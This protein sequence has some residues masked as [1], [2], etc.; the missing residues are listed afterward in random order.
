MAD[1][2][3]SKHGSRVNGGD[4]QDEHLVEDRARQYEFHIEK[5]MPQHARP[6]PMA[7]QLLSWLAA[8]TRLLAWP[9][10][11]PAHPLQMVM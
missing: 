3:H 5:P 11:N 2:V 7:A 9:Q 8:L 1:M 10:R 6:I 4:Q